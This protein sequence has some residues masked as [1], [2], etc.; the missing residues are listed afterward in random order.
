MAK[1]IFIARNTIPLANPAGLVIY[2][3]AKALSNL[4]HNVE[5]FSLNK[6]SGEQQIPKW[7]TESD[8]IHVNGVNLTKKNILFSYLKFLF[9]LSGT[10]KKELK[11]NET[12]YIVTHTNPLYTHWIGF[13]CKL[14]FNKRIKWISSFT[15][16]YV[17]SPFSGYAK[18]TFGTCV[19]ILEQRLSFFFSDKIVFVTDTMRDFI[20]NGNKKALNKSIVVPFFYLSNWKEKILNYDKIKEKRNEQRLLIMHAGSIYGNR[21]ASK[22][23]DALSDH[24]STIIFKNFGVVNQKIQYSSANIVITSPL[25]YDDMMVNLKK[26][27][28]ILIIDSFFKDIK[29]PYMPSKVVDAMYL[30]KPIIGIT[31]S[32]SEL[33]FFLRK[34]GNISIPNDRKII[35][36]VLSNLKQNSKCDFSMYADLNLSDKFRELEC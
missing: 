32:N 9:S 13:I 4:K 3:I 7:L 12:I 26:A 18:F 31:E 15:D 28:Y 20:C 34:T 14:I 19:R 21:D 36:S 24:E 27:D 22:F 23:I 29:N 5:I 1:Y 16:P 17:R 8:D 2:R 35:S 11:K 33:D 6:P 10:I 25:P 30:H